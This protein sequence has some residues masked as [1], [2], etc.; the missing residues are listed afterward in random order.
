MIRITG[1]SADA[2][3][4][5]NQASEGLAQLIAR[6]HEASEAATGVGTVLGSGGGGSGVN[7]GLAQFSAR[8]REAAEAAGTIGRAIGGGGGNGILGSGFTF[9]GLGGGLTGMFGALGEGIMGVVGHMGNFVSGWAQMQ[10]ALV[11][12]EMFNAAANS[13]RN[14]ADSLFELNKQTETNVYSW[15]YTYASTDP[16][17]GKQMTPAQALANAQ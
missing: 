12:N 8:A 9:G 13:V 11:G 15:R 2:V 17:T 4:A 5:M 14:F 1:T 6:S 3:A 7:E 16:A 10:L